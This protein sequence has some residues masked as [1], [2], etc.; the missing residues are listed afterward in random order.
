VAALILAFALLASPAAADPVSVAAVVITG[1][2]AGAA[3]A[4]FTLFGS[5]IAASVAIAVAGAAATVGLNIAFA[6]GRPKRPPLIRDL[7][8]AQSITPYRYA[9]GRAR[10]TG[11]PAPALVSGSTLYICSLLNSRP[12]SGPLTVWLDDRAV[13]WDS[14]AGLIDMAVGAAA[15][16]APFAGYVK[17][18]LGLGGQTECPPEIV[19]AIPDGTDP[20][21]W[22]KASDAWRGRTVLWLKLEVGP[23]SERQ[24]RWPSAPPDV[25]ADG[26]W[27]FVWDC[28]DPGQHA[29]DPSSWRFSAN[30]A[31]C[32][33]DALRTN[34][35]RP[36]PIDQIRLDDF[37]DAARSDSEPVA[38]AN[39]GTEPRYRVG[40]VIVWSGDELE[41]QVTPLVEAGASALIRVGGRLGMTP[42]VWTPPVAT[43]GDTLD[44][45][46]Y[47]VL[48]PGRDLASTVS[49]TYVSP[50]HGWSQAALTPYDA[51]GAVEADGERTT[52]EIDLGMVTSATQAQR[53]QK[54]T[55]LRQRAQ[56]RVTLVAPPEAFEAVAGATVTVTLPSPY[57][58]VD[59]KYQIVDMRPQLLDAED[60]GVALRCALEMTEHVASAYDW[61]IADERPVT[62]GVAVDVSRT[63][64]AAPGPI[65]AVSGAAAA[66]ETGN[67]QTA[68]IAYSFAPSVS[69]SVEFYEIEHRVSGDEW[70]ATTVL[71]ADIR[72]VDGDVFGV[73]SPVTVGALYDIRARARGRSPS[74]WVTVSGVQA[75]APNYALTSPTNGTPVGGA[76]EIAIS[77]TA[78]NDPDFRGV[79]FWGGDTVDIADAQRIAGP[80][81]GPPGTLYGYTETGLGAAQT[82]RYWSRSVGPYGA[83]SDF[84]GPV[85][86]TTDP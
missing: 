15:T 38:L 77:A 21:D 9:Y 10:V 57:D 75:L 14:Q 23:N 40:G 13:E 46:S 19:A 71:G 8:R 78:P 49:A 83:V 82:R 81:Y 36:Y 28:N 17:G 58:A 73:V 34:P 11:T 66:L 53:I 20:A 76:G 68:R 4:G 26:D 3:G 47:E 12:S 67:G 80:L 42:G 41:R 31:L 18:W 29:D 55:A 79:E 2:T 86:A 54:I 69:A 5:T 27:S 43:I 30:R 39:G 33:L 32:V 64:P 7:A 85:T 37:R 63:G 62:Q 16:N 6:P 74:A 61:T 35:V 50:E 24:D 65:T 1:A 70:G 48:R 51:P 84:A 25:E 22:F 45:M 52:V 44:G 72:D 60:G 59:G 56:R